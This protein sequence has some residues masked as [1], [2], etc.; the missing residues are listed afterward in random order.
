MFLGMIVSRG[1]LLT[2]WVGS[3]DQISA[4]VFALYSFAWLIHMPAHVL[5]LTLVSRAR[6]GRMA[7]L[8]LV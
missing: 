8:V 7:P 6:H 1:Q 4:T 2:I 5:F 3:S